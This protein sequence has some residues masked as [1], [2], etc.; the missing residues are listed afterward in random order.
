MNF[1]FC[2]IFVFVCLFIFQDKASGP[3]FVD[4]LALNSDTSLPLPLM[5]W[6]LKRPTNHP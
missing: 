2:L 3:L 4:R 6:G 1:V 5:C